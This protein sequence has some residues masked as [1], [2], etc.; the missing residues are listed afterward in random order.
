[1]SDQRSNFFP[2]RLAIESNPVLAR[3][4]AAAGIDLH[5]HHDP[6]P[7]SAPVAQPGPRQKG[8]TK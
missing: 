7:S 6:V 4:L 2:S 5:G 8:E 3:S 1:M